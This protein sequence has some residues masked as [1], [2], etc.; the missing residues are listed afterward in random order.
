MVQGRGKL[1]YSTGTIK[2]PQEDDPTYQ[3]GDV[4]NS[5]VMG[6]LINSME[7]AIGQLYLFLPNAKDIWELQRKH[8][9]MWGT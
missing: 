8:N 4:E 6:W 9:L 1:G 5:T 3:K 7:E 2:A